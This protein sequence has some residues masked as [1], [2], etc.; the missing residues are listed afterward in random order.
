MASGKARNWRWNNT[1]NCIRGWVVFPGWYYA[2]GVSLE[3]LWRWVEKRHHGNSG[4]CEFSMI[5]SK[6]GCEELSKNVQEF[7]P[8]KMEWCSFLIQHWK[9]QQGTCSSV[10]R[11]RMALLLHLWVQL[12]P[13]GIRMGCL[14]MS[15]GMAGGVSKY[16]T[17]EAEHR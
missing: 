8:F 5:K 11:D 16:L 1:F 9:E 4:H 2:K 12:W 13:L 10:D 17:K 7:A 6:E 14:L 15:K 3:S